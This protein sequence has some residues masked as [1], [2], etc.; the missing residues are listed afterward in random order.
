MEN[1]LAPTIENR[2]FTIRGKQ[3]MFDRDLA[4]LFEVQAKAMNQAVKRNAKRFPIEFMFQLD[5]K[6]FAEWRSQIV[7]SK[8][9]IKGLRKRPY[10]FTEQGIAML[11]TV[12]RSPIAVEVSIRIMNVF[13]ALRKQALAVQVYDSRFQLIENTLSRHEQNFELLFTQLEKHQLPKHGI[14]FNN[15]I[16]DA[17]AF[18]S[19]LIQQATS[20]VILIDNYIDHAVLLQLAK[21]TKGVTATIYTERIPASLSL[22]LDKHNAQY[23]TIDIH[24]MPYIHDRFLIIDEKELYHIGASIKD[25]GKKWFAFSRMDSLVGEVLRRIAKE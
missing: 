22:D 1:T 25:L 13:V 16:F 23:P 17:Y 24:R 4:K 5:V 9:D 7:T 6:E 2:I 12:L 14:F 10:A 15:Q 19:D 3:V 21:R 8:G 11:S 18:F 20:S